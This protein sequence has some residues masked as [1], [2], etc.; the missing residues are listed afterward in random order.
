MMPARIA[1]RPCP[2]ETDRATRL[3]KRDLGVAPGIDAMPFGAIFVVAFVVLPA[4][5]SCDVEDDEFF[6]VL[7]GFGFC[8]LSEAADEADFVEHFLAPFLLVCPLSAIHACPTSVLS[9]STPRLGRNLLKGTTACL[10][11]GVRTSKR[12]VADSGRRA[13]VRRAWVS[14]ARHA[15]RRQKGKPEGSRPV[16]RFV[17]HARECA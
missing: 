3:R 2:N 11:A 1:S 13:C 17:P 7:N 12:R 14:G 5:L 15:E 6:V 8:V 16:Q 4:F 9:R 10:G